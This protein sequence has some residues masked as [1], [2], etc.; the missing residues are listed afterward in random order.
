[1]RLGSVVHMRVFVIAL[2]L[3]SHSCSKD[4]TPSSSQQ[5]QAGSLR[6]EPSSV[7]VSTNQT[8]TVAVSAGVPPYLIASAPSPNLATAQFVNASLD[9][10][11]LSITGVSV[12]TGSTSVRIKDSSPSPE[13]E[14]T[15]QISKVP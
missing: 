7:T 1:M 9:T 4:E 14:I 15:I 12:A 2:I 11:V 3:A 5:Q 13:K 10:S 6:A 8:R